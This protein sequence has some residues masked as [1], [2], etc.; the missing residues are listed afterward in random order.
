MQVRWTSSAARQVTQPRVQRNWQLQ[1]IEFKISCGLTGSPKVVMQAT[2]FSC[3]QVVEQVCELGFPKL[4]MMYECLLQR[5]TVNEQEFDIGCCLFM[6]D[7]ILQECTNKQ[8][9]ALEILQQCL[10]ALNTPLYKHNSRCQ[11]HVV[12][13]QAQPDDLGQLQETDTQSIY[14]LPH[15]RALVVGWNK[16]CCGQELCHTSLFMYSETSAS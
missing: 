14:Q 12:S 13:M 15:A 8:C 6:L 10:I 3:C 7:L 5:P 2:Q 1:D 4:A 16:H 11:R 9:S